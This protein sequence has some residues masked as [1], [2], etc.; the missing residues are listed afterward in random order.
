MH[1]Q[2]INTEAK[3]SDISAAL[4]V[5][6]QRECSCP[7]SVQQSIFSC[8]GTDDSRAAVFLAELS[9]TALPGAVNV[10]SLLDTWVASTP[11]ITVASTQL[12]VDMAC[13]VQVNSSDGQ[14]CVPT[15]TTA[16]TVPSTLAA[17]IGLYV[18][19]ATDLVF[20]ITLAL[21]VSILAVIC[22]RLRKTKQ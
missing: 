12:Q 7:L 10:P 5:S 2:D 6:L 11:R 4:S 9:Y 20:V 17:N 16:P 8:L 19:V 21:V 22:H 14:S 18:L 3:L 15:T 13:S 1:T